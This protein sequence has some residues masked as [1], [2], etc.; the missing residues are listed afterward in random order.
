MNRHQDR[1]PCL[2][3]IS[4]APAIIFTLLLIAMITAAFLVLTSCSAKP[5]EDIG[6]PDI[7]S[8]T[9]SPA[10]N[11]VNGTSAADAKS[12]DTSVA[13]TPPADLPAGDTADKARTITEDDPAA[14]DYAISELYYFCKATPEVM[15]SAISAFPEICQELGYETIDP[16]EM[17]DSLDSEGGGELQD[18]TLSAL[19]EL[20][21]SADTDV[22]LA[23]Y[24]GTIEVLSLIQRD[25]AAPVTPE[26]MTL[27]WEEMSIEDDTSVLAVSRERNDGTGKD[28]AYFLM[29]Y[30]YQRFIPKLGGF[31]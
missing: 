25:T 20:L 16:I 13:G 30:Q 18:A 19:K 3:P 14:I 23:S 24:S 15:I 21:E 11:S 31:M 26:N 4:P 8:A 5:E 22:V 17:D 2:T 28:F 6:E 12:K 27:Y 1:T 29:D 7:P 10:T 9:D